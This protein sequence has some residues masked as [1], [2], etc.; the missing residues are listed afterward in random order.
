MDFFFFFFFNE[1]LGRFGTW[2]KGMFIWLT[3]AAQRTPTEL[4]TIAQREKSR[5]QDLPLSLAQHLI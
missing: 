5:R 1:E 2:T 3:K 4:R